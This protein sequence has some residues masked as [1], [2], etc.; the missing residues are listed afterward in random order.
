MAM[1]HFGVQCDSHTFASEVA[2]LIISKHALPNISDYELESI[3][4][5]RGYACSMDLEEAIPEELVEEVLSEID[6]KVAQDC[7][8][9]A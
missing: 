5:I 3:L 6:V 1:E 7:C 8:P 2:S 4:N 9:R